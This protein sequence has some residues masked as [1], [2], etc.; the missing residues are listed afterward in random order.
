MIEDFLGKENLKLGLEKY[1]NRYMYRT[2]KT[3][4]LWE[5]L[6]EVSTQLPISV[7]TIMDTWIIQQGFP[8]I[9]ARWHSDNEHIIVSQHR[10]VSSLSPE[11]FETQKAT[12]AS[13]S[14]EWIVPLTVIDART[15]K[16]Q[17]YWLNSSSMTIPL[18]KKENVWFKLN[19]QQSGFYRVNYDISIWRNMI[20]QLV[21]AHPD[22]QFLSASDRAGLIDDALS[23][24][25]IG[26][27]D[28][29]TA[30][31]LTRYLG[32]IDNAFLIQ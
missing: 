6:S 1:L 29:N 3:A 17:L 22:R 18:S 27:L 11:E 25:R 20:A 31:D 8:V 16:S 32:E 30:M 15:N 14:Q 4:Q 10:F 2:A 5:A 19:Y 23:L 21:N 28:V 7:S 26:Q 24:M 12:N 13:L 9:K